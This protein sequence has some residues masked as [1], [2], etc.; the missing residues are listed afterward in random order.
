MKGLNVVTLNQIVSDLETESNILDGL[1]TI[2]DP[3]EMIDLIATI[4]K[5][6]EKV[7]DVVLKLNDL[8][9]RLSAQLDVFVDPKTKSTI[10][11]AL[12]HLLQIIK[13]L[14]LFGGMPESYKIFEM[15]PDGNGGITFK[16]VFLPKK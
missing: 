9:T 5:R 7:M 11:E 10:A 6:R 4:N 14:S 15:I 12:H 2:S 13:N 16:S 8:H 1:K 3:N